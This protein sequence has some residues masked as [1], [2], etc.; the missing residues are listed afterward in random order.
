MDIGLLSMAMSQSKVQELAGIEVMK[1]A[2]DNGEKSAANITDMMKSCAVN[3]DLGNNLDV[4][5]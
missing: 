5:A 4:F 3:P 1:M 2:M